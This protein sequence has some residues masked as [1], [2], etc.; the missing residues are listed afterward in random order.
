MIL[1]KLPKATQIESA[2]VEVLTKV[3]LIPQPQL[4]ITISP[5]SPEGMVNNNLAILEG[6]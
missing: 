2:R 4:P 1:A 3:S 5:D 6:N